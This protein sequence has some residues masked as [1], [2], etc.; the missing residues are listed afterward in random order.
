MCRPSSLERREETRSQ[1]EEENHPWD[2]LGLATRR[3]FGADRC[4]ISTGVYQGERGGGGNVLRTSEPSS[5][6]NMTSSW[7]SAVLSARRRAAFLR[8]GDGEIC[9]WSGDSS[10]LEGETAKKVKEDGTLKQTEP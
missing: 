1:G 4:E 2:R 5:S 8:E 7:G 6:I 10:M 9:L 3:Y